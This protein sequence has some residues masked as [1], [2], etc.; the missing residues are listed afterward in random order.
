MKKNL[1]ALISLILF[2]CGGAGPLTDTTQDTVPVVLADEAAALEAIRDVREA[3]TGFMARQRRYAQFMEELVDALM[4][5]GE[6]SWA[7]SGY[8]IRIRPTPAADGYSATVTAPADATDVRS[9]YVDDS[10]VI[11]WAVGEAANA[12]SPVLEE[13]SDTGDVSPD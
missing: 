2:G 4:I 10:G 6:P 8:L 3:Q 7:R 9:F 12:D 1:A 13:D 5:P 11:R